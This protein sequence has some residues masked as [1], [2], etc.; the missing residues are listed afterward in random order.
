MP[1]PW[2]KRLKLQAIELFLIQQFLFLKWK[3]SWISNFS[4]HNFFGVND[5]FKFFCF[6]DFFQDSLYRI[7]TSSFSKKF[8]RLLKCMINSTFNL[9]ILKRLQHVWKKVDFFFYRAWFFLQ[10]HFYFLIS[11]RA[12]HKTLLAWYLFMCS[13]KYFSN[14]CW[15]LTITL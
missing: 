7:D 12:V 13:Y 6:A 1:T 9:P 11:L 10:T 15:T 4:F 3:W 8:I 14:V 2:L 5:N